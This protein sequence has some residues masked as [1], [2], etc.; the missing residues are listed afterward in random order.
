MISALQQFDDITAAGILA[1]AALAIDDNPAG[2]YRLPGEAE[3]R[4]AVISEA[5]LAHGLDP[6]DRTP[7]TLEQLGDILDFERETLIA[8][9]NANAALERLSERGHLPSDLF[10][11]EIIP[12]ISNF[13][14]RKYP[15]EEKIIAETVRSPDREQHY[16]PPA[17]P[18]EPFLIS[19]FAREYRNKFPLR[20]FTMLVAG[21]RKGL[22]LAVHQ[23][24]RVYPSE[25]NLEGTS[26]LVDML[27][28][29]SDSF[30]A[31]IQIGN[32]RG[33]FIL[34]AALP[35]NQPISASWRLMQGEPQR[36]GR[37]E[38]H[39][40]TVTC[41]AQR[42]PQGQATQAALAVGIDLNRYQRVLESKGY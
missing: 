4:N 34:A 26:S 35:Q 6:D 24:W 13:H 8:P 15:A 11:I 41:F 7:K 33:H 36:I 17:R 27:Q 1:R 10:K 30:G 23:A 38:K 37:K 22:S 29:F 28:R 5:R 9:T 12:N 40:I 18:E 16:G 3:L 14:G 31:E 25:V 20:T 39:V 42:G 19:L 32:Q 21:Q 2:S